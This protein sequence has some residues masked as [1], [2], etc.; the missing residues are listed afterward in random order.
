VLKGEKRRVV[1][2]YPSAKPLGIDSMEWF[3]SFEH[4][5]VTEEMLKSE[6][7]TLNYRISTI[8]ED[9]E[10]I[11]CDDTVWSAPIHSLSEEP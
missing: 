10:R 9:K 3:L 1:L 8:Y 11:L 5:G 7:T 2:R 6:E 4:L